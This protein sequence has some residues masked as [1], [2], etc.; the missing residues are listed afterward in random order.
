MWR[1]VLTAASCIA[2][3]AALYSRSGIAAT[4]RSD[5]A[6]LS[7]DVCPDDVEWSAAARSGEI[8]GTPQVVSMGADLEALSQPAGRHAL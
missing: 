4:G 2:L 8:A 1:D 3:C 7:L 6:S 5:R